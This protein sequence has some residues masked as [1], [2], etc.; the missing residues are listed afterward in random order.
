MEAGGEL[1][2]AYL[3]QLTGDALPVL[4]DGLGD[5]PAP[6]VLAVLACQA[7]LRTGAQAD[8]SWQAWHWG[9]RQAAEALRRVQ[10]RLVRYAV[11][12]EDGVWMVAGPGVPATPC[13]GQWL[14]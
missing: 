6:E 11:D 1:D 10:V 5:H 3:G 12:R 14:D 7:K 4:V 9:R 2:L 13:H 8:P